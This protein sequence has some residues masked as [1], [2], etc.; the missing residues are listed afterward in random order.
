MAAI[1]KNRTLTILN[2]AAAGNYG[3]LAYGAPLQSIKRN[4]DDL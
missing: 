3:V 4:T 1:K 2:A